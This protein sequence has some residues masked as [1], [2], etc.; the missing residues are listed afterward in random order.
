[1]DDAY[2]ILARNKMEGESFSEVIRRTVSKKKNIRKFIGAWKDVSDKEIEEMKA[3]IMKL[4]K[5]GTM[6]LLKTV[7]DL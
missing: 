1:M 5:R 4:R 3:D 2:E 6:D 7:K